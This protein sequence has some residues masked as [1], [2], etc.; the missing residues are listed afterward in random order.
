[1]GPTE[2]SE[3]GGVCGQGRGR[4]WER[5]KRAKRPHMP[6]TLCRKRRRSWWR[7]P[8]SS[9]RKTA[10]RSARDLALPVPLRQNGGSFSPRAR[11]PLKI[12]ALPTVTGHANNTKTASSRVGILCQRRAALHAA[13]VGK[14]P[15]T[16]R[17]AGGLPPRPEGRGPCWVLSGPCWLSQASSDAHAA[18]GALPPRLALALV[19]ACERCACAMPCGCAPCDVAAAGRAS[20][21]AAT[22]IFWLMRACEHVPKMA[23]LRAVL[24]WGFW[25]AALDGCG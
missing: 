1:M 19:R 6:D 21:R 12:N 4:E 25:R 9:L 11:Q 13:R 5:A 7:K 18:R 16:G 2:R 24:L 10:S 3:G 22:A 17:R 23:P 20:E 14:R 15:S 8:V